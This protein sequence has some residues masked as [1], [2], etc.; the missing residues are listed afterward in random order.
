MWRT[1][2]QWSISGEESRKKWQ[3]RQERSKQLP[4]PPPISFLPL[5]PPSSL[6]HTLFITADFPLAIA[7][8][9]NPPTP[10]SFTWG[11]ASA[12]GA[13]CHLRGFY[14]NGT[15]TE[16]CGWGG[17]RGGGGVQANS[18]TTTMGLYHLAAAAFKHM[19][20]RGGC[21]VE[22]KRNRWQRLQ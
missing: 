7:I 22:D 4:A 2:N 11:L 6:L 8:V 18:F 12:L 15:N 13:R 14:T 17:G 5:L 1:K 16:P 20:G 21:D 19:N 3:G 10:T 9:S